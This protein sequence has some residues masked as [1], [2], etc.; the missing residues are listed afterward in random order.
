L[1]EIK[2]AEAGLYLVASF[3]LQAL[4]L[5]AMGE[6]DAAL[7]AIE[8]ALTLAEPESYVRTFVDEGEPMAQLLRQAIAHGI[9][10][11]YAGKLLAAL[12]SEMRGEQRITELVEPLSERELEVLRLL[13]THLS[14]TEMAEE[15]SI[16]ASTVR[17]HIKSIYGKLNVHSRKDAILRAKELELF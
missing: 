15:L 11:E 5:M 4:A 7:E 17:S 10:V 14:S 8:S 9:A 12:E 6:R 16:A 1:E 13:T 3:A 2:A